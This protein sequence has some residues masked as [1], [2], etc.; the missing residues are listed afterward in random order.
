[1]IIGRRA[2]LKLFGA[3]GVALSG[4]GGMARK[5][6]LGASVGTLSLRKVTG[7]DAASLEAI[8]N[9]CV[10][11]V[12]AFHGKCNPWSRGWAD[13]VVQRKTESL[14]LTVDG[15]PAAFFELAPIG[16]LPPPPR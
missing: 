10:S 15:A 13:H 2:V 6:A 4:F 5:P 3:F 14:L 9:S 8:M 1:M 11:E 7:N 12:G 16:N